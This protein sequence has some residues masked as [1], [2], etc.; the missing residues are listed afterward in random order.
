MRGPCPRTRRA[1]RG[2]RDGK[3]YLI[4]TRGQDAADHPRMEKAAFPIRKAALVSQATG[5][6]PYQ[7]I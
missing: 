6:R 4:E 1:D 3:R 5:A 7:R 2:G